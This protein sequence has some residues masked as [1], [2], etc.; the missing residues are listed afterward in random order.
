MI[1]TINESNNIAAAINS[2]WIGGA[3]EVFVVDGG[4]SDS[5]LAIAESQRATVIQCLLGRA[6]QMNSGASAATSDIVLFLHAD[7]ELPKNFTQQ[8][9]VAISSKNAHR[10]GVFWQAIRSP[11]H[12]FRL[13]E[14]GNY[15]RVRIRNLAYGDQGIWI[16]RELFLELGGFPELPIME[17]YVFSEKLPRNLKYSILKGPLSVSA[18][19]W[20]RHG[21]IRQT[22]RN[23]NIIAQ[24]KKGR[25]LTELEKSY[26]R[27]DITD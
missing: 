1:P 25:S 20:E 13:L 23:W 18:R 8:I 3:S 10:I 16:D 12:S 27:H 5:T 7:C 6:V 21:I 22:M 19:R 26:N 4:S 24:Y 14:S 15:W 9:R 17:D 2:A 11:R